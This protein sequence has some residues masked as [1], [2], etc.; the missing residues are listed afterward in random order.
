[1]TETLRLFFAGVLLAV[2]VPWYAA[3][4]DDSKEYAVKAAYLYNFTKFIEW[5]ET[6]DKIINLCVVGDNP[7]GN[8][9]QLL[10]KKKSGSYTLAVRERVTKSNIHTCQVIFI[11]TGASE[12]EALLKYLEGKPVLTVSDGEGFAKSGGMIGFVMLHNRVKLEINTK[13]MQKVNL[14]VDPTLLE[15]ALRVVD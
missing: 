3:R 2:M 12:R 6:P 10:E 7:F 4:A 11:R 15:I 13:A 14:Q 9:L 1:M 5:P 8:A